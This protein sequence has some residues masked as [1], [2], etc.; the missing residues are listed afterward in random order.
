MLEIETTQSGWRATSIAV[1]TEHRIRAVEYDRTNN[2]ARVRIGDYERTQK[3]EDLADV[4]GSV[5]E[6]VVSGLSPGSI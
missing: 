6:G 5:A 3:T 2:A 1:F 4:A